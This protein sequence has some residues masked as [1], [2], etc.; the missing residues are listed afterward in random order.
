MALLCPENSLKRK[1]AHPHAKT[2]VREEV[3]SCHK[4]FV[5][6]FEEKEGAIAATSQGQFLNLESMYLKMSL[7]WESISSP[8]SESSTKGSSPE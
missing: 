6:D 4:K 1:A 5:A 8:S 7:A 3:R 2:A